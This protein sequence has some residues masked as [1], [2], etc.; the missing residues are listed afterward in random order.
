MPRRS[1]GGAGSIFDQIQQQA[2]VI[3]STLREEI[4]AKEADL[5]RLK[6][7][8]SRLALVTAEVSTAPAGAGLTPDRTTGG[9]MN[10]RTVIER[11]PKQFKASDVRGIRGLKDKRTSELFSAV[12]RW[13]DAG[14][15]KRKERGLY[16][17]VS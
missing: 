17:R 14:I 6:E 3:L 15:V 7:E 13:I 4:R 11:L 8:E 9:R 12:T 1:S 10:W 5:K 16:E 2:R